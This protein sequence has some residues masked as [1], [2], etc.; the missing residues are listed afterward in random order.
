[1]GF[2][3]R[4]YLLLPSEKLQEGNLRFRFTSFLVGEK[5]HRHGTY[6]IFSVKLFDSFFIPL[7][8]WPLNIASEKSINN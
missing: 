7:S 6:L 3:R 1:M 8:G 2:I 4:S 5:E